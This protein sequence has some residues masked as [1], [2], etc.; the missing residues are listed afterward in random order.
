MRPTVIA[1]P[2]LLNLGSDLALRHR[3]FVKGSF[4]HPAKLHCGLYQWM[5]WRYTLPGDT[6][7]DCMA[8]VESFRTGETAQ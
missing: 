4:A 5:V 1:A 3:Y 8:G 7:A 2:Q 6:I